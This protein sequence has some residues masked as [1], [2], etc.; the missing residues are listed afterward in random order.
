MITRREFLVG[1]VCAQAVFARVAFGDP[2]YPNG[3]VRIIVPFAPGGTTDIVGRYAGKSLSEIFG[4]PFVVENRSGGRGAIGTNI[5][6]TSQGDGQALL[7]GSASSLVLNPVLSKSVPFDPINDFTPVGVIGSAFAVLVVSPSLPVQNVDDL[8]ALAK[9]KPGEIN[10]ASSGTGS[11]PHIFME[12]FKQ[13]AGIDLLHIPYQG[14]GPALVDL[15]SGQGGAVMM[16]N[17]PVVKE[18][19][20]A[21]KIKALAVNSK[22]RSPLLPDVPTMAESGYGGF[23]YS[24]WFGIL[25]P[26]GTP[27]PIVMQLNGAIG[28]MVQ[29]EETIQRL[30]ELGLVAEPLSPGD[31]A[32]LIKNDL[33]AYDKVINTL[34]IDSE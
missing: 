31:F 20:K 26:A 18:Q 10:Y 28:K 24:E 12:M 4:T 17:I 25:A 6:A 9:S 27:E 34:Q 13:K 7:L 14:T 11:T 1:A 3:A 5:V 8:I 19:I 29:E 22:E 33:N 21:G 16:P 23:E 30:S 2:A 15:M 32:K